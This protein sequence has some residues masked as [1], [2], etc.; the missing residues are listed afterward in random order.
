M[1]QRPSA[2]KAEPQSETD[3]RERSAALARLIA[4]AR[5]EAVLL[6]AHFL[7]YCL[8]A[9][10]AAAQEDFNRIPAAPEELVSP[11]HPGTDQMQLSQLH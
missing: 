8:D 5:D 1:S 3:R 4:Y 7:A 6:D 9:S 2:D 11:T 10:L